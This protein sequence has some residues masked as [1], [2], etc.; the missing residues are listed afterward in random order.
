MIVRA[1]I[2]TIDPDRAGDVVVPTGLRNADEY[3]LNPVVLWAHQRTHAADRHVRV[4]DVQ[5]RP[6]RRRD[7]VR[8]GVPF[9]AGR[10]RL[11]EQGVLRGWSIGFVPAQGA[12]DPA[13]PR[14]PPAACATRSGTCSNTRPCRSRRTRRR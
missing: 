12:S 9:A 5:P 4:A 2:T 8:A 10:V 14:K 11:Y 7:E 6:H 1:V 3:L 13:E